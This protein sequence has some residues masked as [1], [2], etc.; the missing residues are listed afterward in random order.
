VA[1]PA[2]V[3]TPVDVLGSATVA[4]DAYYY[5]QEPPFAL[6]GESTQQI[7]REDELLEGLEVVDKRLLGPEGSRFDETFNLA[8]SPAATKRH[9]RIAKK[10]RR[11]RFGLMCLAGALSGSVYGATELPIPILQI[12][13][14]D[15]CK[16]GGNVSGGQYLQ[17]IAPDT[18]IPSSVLYC[19][20]AGQ[21]YAISNVPHIEK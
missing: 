7:A 14:R 15:S 21:K 6:T 20:L 19:T 2:A 12:L 13:P 11:Y 8:R 3:L 16:L 9:E 18:K 1:V 17:R 10:A 5:W 4:A